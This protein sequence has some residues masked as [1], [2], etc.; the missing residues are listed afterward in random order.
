MRRILLVAALVACSVLGTQAQAP[1]P[2][3]YGILNSTTCPGSGCL[4]I[5]VTGNSGIGVQINNTGTYTAQFEASIDGVTFASVNLTAL[6]TATTVTSATAPGAWSGGVGGMVV[7]RVRLSVCTGCSVAVYQLAVLGGGGGGGSAGSVT[8]NDPNTISQKAAVNASGQLS[9]TCANCSGSGASAVD[10]SAFTVGTTS[11]APGMGLFMTTPST[12]T[13]GTVGALGMDSRRQLFTVIRDAADN[14]RGVNV[15]AGNALLV[16][17]SATTQPVSA[18]SLPLPTGASTA[19]KQPALGTAGTPATDVISVQGV[20]SMTALKVDGSGVTQPVS[21]TVTA[22]AGTNMS[23]ASLALESGGNLQSITTNTAKIPSKGSATSAN[24][25]PVVIAS[26]QANVP[27]NEAQINGV[28]PLMSNG[29]S[30]TG[31]QRVN[32]A[33]DNTVLPAVGAGA[34]GS[35]VPA[36]A[37]VPGGQNSA[38]NLYGDIVCDKGVIYDASTSGSTQLVAVSASTHVYICGYEV[39]AAGTVNVSLVAGTGT[40]CASA[41]SGANSVGTSGAAAKLTPA[42]EFTAST[43]KISAWPGHGW[44]IDAG[45]ANA[46]CLNTNGAVAVQAEI[47]YSQR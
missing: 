6:G 36:N 23:T 39:F 34:T 17:A 7:F 10:E 22:N 24:S 1:T 46:V 26:D 35:A 37:V 14:L 20:T 8:I 42:W 18:A 2:L 13:T 47:F 38:G 16:D 3:V 44:L 11:G 45:S 4:N 33:S 29:V 21:G 40:A 9:I 19:A 41:A 28:T 12:L 30:G 25:T 43:G 27:T 5:P 32:I 15:S 31:S